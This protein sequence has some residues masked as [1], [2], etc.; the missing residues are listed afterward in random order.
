MKSVT[1]K[2]SQDQTFSSTKFL[3]FHFNRTKNILKICLLTY[4]KTLPYQPNLHIFLLFKKSKIYLFTYW[5][6]SSHQLYLHMISSFLS[7]TLLKPTLKLANFIP[8]TKFSQPHSKWGWEHL[9]DSKDSNAE[10]FFK[11]TYATVKPFS[12]CERRYPS[13]SCSI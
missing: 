9:S 8:S 3:H 1:R 5:E 10:M 13:A 4:W 12:F 7:R 2:H 6:T 11:S